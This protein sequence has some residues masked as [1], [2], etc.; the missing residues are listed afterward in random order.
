MA[1]HEDVTVEI[2]DDHVALVEMH[3]PP[4]NYFDVELIRALADAF[5]ALADDKR[6]RVI[7]LASEGKHFCAGANFGSP[8]GLGGDDGDPTLAL[9]RE[10]VRLVAAPI[11]VVAVVQGAAIGGGLGVACAADFRVASPQARF[12]ANFARLGFHHGFGLTATLPEI[13]GKQHALDL[14]YTGRR[15]NGERAAAIGLVDLLVSA[16]QLR[17]SARDFAREIAG[18]A[19][20]AVRSI[21]A[22]MRGHLADAV[23]KAVQR[24]ASEQAELRS[25]SDFAEGIRAT[26]ERRE[27]RFTGQ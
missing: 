4:E 21:R 14:L 15:I 25:T 11:P 8:R 17:E 12:A 3:R 16:E 27:P 2:G 23:E 24:E 20:L 22:T 1:E 26:A 10:A 9:Y 18:S 5:E 19:P 7:L 13:V 6:C